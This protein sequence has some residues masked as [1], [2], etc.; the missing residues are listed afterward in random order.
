MGSTLIICLA[1]K[2]FECCTII[3]SQRILPIIIHTQKK[4]VSNLNATMTK[5][6]NMSQSLVTEKTEQYVGNPSKYKQSAT[7]VKYDVL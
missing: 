5:D 3:L 1:K 2:M 7:E 4:L 6:K